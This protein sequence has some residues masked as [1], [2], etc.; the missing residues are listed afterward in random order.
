[1]KKPVSF[2]FNFITSLQALAVD[3]KGQRVEPGIKFRLE[4]RVY[5][6]MPINARLIREYIRYYFNPKMRFTFR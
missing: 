6:A 4:N 5:H 1:M 2:L 3:L